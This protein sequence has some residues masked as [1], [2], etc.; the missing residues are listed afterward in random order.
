M[1]AD[2]PSIRKLQPEFVISPG[3]Q[4]VVKV[5]KALP[6]GE[7]YKPPGTRYLT[8]SRASQYLVAIPTSPVIH[9]QN[10]APG[11]PRAI[12]V[13]TPTI[14]PVPTVAESAVINA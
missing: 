2:T 12:A 4:V 9:I 14:L 3:T 6:C 10:R 13:A 1:S 7:E 8:D 11:P 5:A